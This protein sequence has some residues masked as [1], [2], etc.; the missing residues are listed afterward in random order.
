MHLGTFEPAVVGKMLA[1]Y[2]RCIGP[3]EH[4]DARLPIK[5]YADTD[6]P[7]RNRYD[8]LIAGLD[9]NC[10]TRPLADLLI[11][12]P[13]GLDCDTD[14][15]FCAVFEVAK[16]I[17]GA[18]RIVSA[19]VHLDEPGAE[20]HMHFAFVP[21][22]E[23][24]VMTNDKTKPLLWNKADEEKNPDHVA[25]TQKKDSKGTLRW[26]R[27]PARDESGNPIV[28][29][30]ASSS[31]LFSRTRMKNLHGEFERALCAKLELERV[32]IALDEDDPTKKWS[33]LEHN[34]FV[35]V[36]TARATEEQKRDAAS[37]EL[38]CLQE[39]C[40]ERQT[41]AEERKKELEEIQAELRTSRERERDLAAENQGLK[42]AVSHLKTI[43]A[44]AIREVA[45]FAERIGLTRHS[46]FAWLE[47]FG[48][49]HVDYKEVDEAEVGLANL[50]TA[51]RGAAEL[52][53]ANSGKVIRGEAWQR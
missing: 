9:F 38:G 17:V 33:K 25:G 34:D 42:A 19:Y 32:G 7:Q 53:N 27:V 41:V 8:E 28:R 15:F 13:K 22:V 26:E 20:P 52:A 36:T 5:N 48:A 2:E 23:T 10:K 49:K 47:Q 24:P 11:T 1:H 29:R 50:E 43:L 21:V 18:E 35:A 40:E 37:A 4:I 30:T 31:K 45:G 39:R 46:G 6:E 16:K 12:K 14:K 51:A 3:R 44:R